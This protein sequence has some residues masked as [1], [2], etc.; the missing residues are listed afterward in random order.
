MKK[1]TDKTKDKHI[2]RNTY[3]Y[4][5][6]IERERDELAP[7]FPQPNKRAVAALSYR[8]LYVVS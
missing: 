4:I 7:L 8:R 1:P 5:Y 2:D 3:V 6:I